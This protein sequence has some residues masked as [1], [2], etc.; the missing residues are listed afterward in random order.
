MVLID[1]RKVNIS[2]LGVQVLFDVDF[3]L[4]SGEIHCL[5]GENGAG[6]STLVKIL[7]GIYTH[8]DGEIHFEGESVRIPDARAA[9]ELGIH[10]VQQHR[11]LVPTMNA[12]ENIFLGAELR[13]DRGM[14][15]VDFVGMEERAREMIDRFGVDMNLGVPVRDLRLSEQ[16]IVAICKALAAEGKVLLVDEAS[17]PLDSGERQVLYGILRRL[18]DEGRG[19]LYISHHL[20]E[21][22]A[23]GERVTVLRNGRRVCTVPVAEMDRDGLIAAMTGNRTLYER[24][25][26]GGVDP[27]AAPVLELRELS[28]PHLTDIS[29]AVRPGEILG[30]AGLE[31]S[32]KDEIARVIFG[33]EPYHA[34]EILHHG[35]P[36][37]PG[38]PIEPI[39]LGVGLVPTDRKNAGLVQCRSVGE[40]I[41]LT[42]INRFRQHLVSPGWTRRQALESIRRLGIK[43]SGPAQLLEYLSGG[44]QQKV[45][46]SKWLQAEA[47]I[48]LLVE[49]TEGIDIGTRADLYVMFKELAGSGKSLILFTS[50]IDELIALCD[51]IYT[52]VEGN[53]IGE[54]PGA[55]ADKRAILADILSKQIAGGDHGTS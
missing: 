18:R 23:I 45:L 25:R 16:G 44:N 26:S 14:R 36:L 2:F 20:E 31:G 12:V 52:M 7:T 43:T 27:E 33:L 10:A 47:E 38:H 50:D 19:I 53:V 55:G 6:K 46:L 37:H 4:R 39:R 11:D 5:C 15:P 40:N 3:D 22:F 48:L 54:Y 41:V 30:F 1:A 49:P 29:F 32:F 8:H 24:A 28:S 9:R 17:A 34:G 13:G 51:R 42:R 21:I 35:R